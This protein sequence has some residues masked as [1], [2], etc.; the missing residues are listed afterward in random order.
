[1][2]FLD[3]EVRQKIVQ[4]LKPGRFFGRPDL[5]F[6]DLAVGRDDGF[7]FRQRLPFFGNG[8]LHASL[9]DV[10]GQQS[11]PGGDKQRQEHPEKRVH[12][13]FPMY[14]RPTATETLWLS[15][16]TQRLGGAS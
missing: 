8:D 10:E 1:M 13:G 6:D 3:P 7:G 2:P 15:Y 5:L 9:H 16:F 11:R 14:Y 4:G 12:T